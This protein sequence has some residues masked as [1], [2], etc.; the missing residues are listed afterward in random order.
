MGNAVGVILPP[1][2]LARLRVQEGDNL[3]ITETLLGVELTR[4]DPAFGKQMTIAQRIMGED[5]AALK[6]LS[7]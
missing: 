3:Y 5:H 6:K 2:I 4:D 7:E 1:E